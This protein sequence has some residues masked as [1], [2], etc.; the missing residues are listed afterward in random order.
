MTEVAL[1]G[2]IPSSYPFFKPRS[3]GSNVEGFPPEEFMNK[4]FIETTITVPPKP[5]DFVGT[6]TKW[7]IAQVTDWFSKA[8]QD[9]APSV[10]LIL[11]SF[12]MTSKLEPEAMRNTKKLLNGMVNNVKKQID[13]F[14]IN[15][16]AASKGNTYQMYLKM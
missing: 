3:P 8:Q 1:D 16:A 2:V 13:Q 12:V 15:T 6:E 7:A 5:K 14:H 9:L 4:V 11:L 10:S